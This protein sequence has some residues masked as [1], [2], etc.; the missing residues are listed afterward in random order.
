LANWVGALETGA[1]VEEQIAFDFLDSTEYLSK[2]DKYFVDH[3]YLALL[4]RGFDPAGE[5]GWLNALGDDSNG[6][7]THGAS[8]THEQV[9]RDFLY[10]TESQT[11]LVK[12]YYQVF[13]HRL[14]DQ[15]GL[16]NWVA[17]L[18]QGES[19][20]TIGQSFLA[21]DEFYNNAALQ[22]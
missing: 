7:P 11:R 22:G 1:L 14:A 8:L 16:N 17:A 21:G 9:I 10:S 19:F 18:G 20:L 5:A 4:G 15:G 12:G 3:M 13:L 2:G 6:N